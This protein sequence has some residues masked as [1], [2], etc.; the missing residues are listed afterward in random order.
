MAE[1]SFMVPLRPT[2]FTVLQFDVER[3]K[4][5]KQSLSFCIYPVHYNIINHRDKEK[6]LRPTQKNRGK[7][8]NDASGYTN[9]K[10]EIC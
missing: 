8:D 4:A 3:K 1:H 5:N 2:P 7:K 6:G 10:A 9:F